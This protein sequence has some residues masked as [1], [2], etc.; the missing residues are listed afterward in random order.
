LDIPNLVESPKLQY[1]PEWLII[2]K[3][4]KHLM[5]NSPNFI[6][7]PT[8]TSFTQNG[9]RYDFRPS[10][11]EIQKVIQNLGDHLDISP[12]NFVQN[13]SIFDAQ[14]PKSVDKQLFDNPQTSKFLEM[15]DKIFS[16]SQIGTIFLFTF[17]QFLA[18]NPDENEF[19]F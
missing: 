7:M 14:N 3:S 1:D 15:I 4:T 2:L 18:K 16:D 9:M 12:E 10:R 5:S 6:S 13:D 17:E 19:D 8:I 11:E